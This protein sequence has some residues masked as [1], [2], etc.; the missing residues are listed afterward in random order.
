MI[1]VLQYTAPA[2]IVFKRGGKMKYKGLY[3]NY[4]QENLYKVPLPYWG[5]VSETIKV[6][7]GLWERKL[8][9]NA[10]GKICKDIDIDLVK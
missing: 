7:T 9:Y 2:E 8:N 1:Y 4:Q 10:L 3:W 6:K 5:Q